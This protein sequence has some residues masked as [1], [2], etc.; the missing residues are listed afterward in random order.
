MHQIHAYLY[1]S[2]RNS[3]V[4]NAHGDDFNAIMAQINDKANRSIILGY[5]CNTIL[6]KSNFEKRL[7]Y[8]QSMISQRNKIIVSLFMSG[9]CDFFSF[10]KLEQGT[11]KGAA[12]TTNKHTRHDPYEYP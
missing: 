11:R 4:L 5:C 6:S 12:K 8:H 10:T 9:L 3:S 1:I 2:T 7:I